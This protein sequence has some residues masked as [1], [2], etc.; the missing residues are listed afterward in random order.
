MAVAVAM[1]F[2]MKVIVGGGFIL[3][4]HFGF[5]FGGRFGLLLKRDEMMVIDGV[6]YVVR[7][8][9]MCDLICGEVWCRRAFVMLRHLCV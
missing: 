2:A 8:D 1:S 6:Q 3:A 9:E 7:C 4:A 5:G